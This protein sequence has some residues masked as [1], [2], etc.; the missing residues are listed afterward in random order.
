M[1]QSDSSEDLL[2]GFSEAMMPVS[3]VTCLRDKET[4]KLHSLPWLRTRRLEPCGSGV[5]N[6]HQPDL[7]HLARAYRALQ[8]GSACRAGA[9][10]ALPNGLPPHWT[11]EHGRSA[12]AEAEDEKEE[13]DIGEDS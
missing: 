3:P 6:R 5:P 13:E 10:R 1:A 12:P 2:S 8:P 9:C 11:V 7:R 4:C